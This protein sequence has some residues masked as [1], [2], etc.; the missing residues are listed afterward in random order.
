MCLC[1]VVTDTPENVHI[2]FQS[3]ASKK[4]TEQQNRVSHI[5][6]CY[7]KRLEQMVRMLLFIRFSGPFIFHRDESDD[8]STNGDSKPCGCVIM[9][10]VWIRRSFEP[11]IHLSLVFLSHLLIYLWIL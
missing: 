2:F 4:P 5:T 10:C 7:N 8:N 6:R 11:I 3:L 1:G 9:F